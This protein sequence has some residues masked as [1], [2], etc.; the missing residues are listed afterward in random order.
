VVI[1]IPE[2]RKFHMLRLSERMSSISSGVPEYSSNLHRANGSFRPG[3]VN[4]GKVESRHL[5]ITYE[6]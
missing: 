1:Y 5:H 3:S 2:V 6:Y 4:P